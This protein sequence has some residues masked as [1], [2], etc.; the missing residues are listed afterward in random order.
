MRG[1]KPSRRPLD[2]RRI[3]FVKRLLAPADAHKAR[4][5]AELVRLEGRG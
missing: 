4:L 3:T 2:A 1:S 5:E